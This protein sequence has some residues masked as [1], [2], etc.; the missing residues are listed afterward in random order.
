MATT[1]PA[2]PHE[3]HIDSTI[4]TIEDHVKSESMTALTGISG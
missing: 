4:K 3:Q 2:A 1:T